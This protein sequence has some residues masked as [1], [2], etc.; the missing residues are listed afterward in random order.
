MR[1]CLWIYQ[2]C[3]GVCEAHATF[4]ALLDAAR[5]SCCC[6]NA[7]GQY[8]ESSFQITLC[9]QKCFCLLGRVK[10]AQNQL[11]YD[12][13]SN[14][15][16]WR[17]ERIYYRQHLVSWG[18]SSFTQNTQRRGW[19]GPVLV[20]SDTAFIEGSPDWRPNILFS[21][22]TVNCKITPRQSLPPQCLASELEMS[23]CCDVFCC[24]NF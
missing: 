6:R 19:G 8:M 17:L 16:D 11:F 5:D 22:F 15:E 12:T 18:L 1:L 10:P 9:R 13:M 7:V 23:Q 21:L 14:S 20:W 2:K 4:I 3:S 24:C